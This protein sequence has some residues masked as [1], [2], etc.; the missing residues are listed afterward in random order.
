MLAGAP[1]EYSGYASGVLAIMR[2]FGQCLGA[3]LVGVL[4]TVGATSASGIAEVAGVRLA[5]WIAAAASLLALA[6]SVS[7]LRKR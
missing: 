2:T 5:L 1:R 7:R 3:A 6:F 4:L